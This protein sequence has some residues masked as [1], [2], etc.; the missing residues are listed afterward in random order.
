MY[1]APTAYQW[2]QGD[3]LKPEVLDPS[4]VEEDVIYETAAACPTQAIVVEQVQDPS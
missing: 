1:L 3:L 2:R 4:T